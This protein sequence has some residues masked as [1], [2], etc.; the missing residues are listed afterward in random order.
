[1]VLF[2][3]RCYNEII[4]SLPPQKIITSFR[5]PPAAVEPPESWHGVWIVPFVDGDRFQ[6]ATYPLESCWDTAYVIRYG[7]IDQSIIDG[8]EYLSRSRWWELGVRESRAL[9]N[10]L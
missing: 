1:M 10:I 2:Y 6:S 8:D 4:Y 9:R 3:E 5:L 7:T